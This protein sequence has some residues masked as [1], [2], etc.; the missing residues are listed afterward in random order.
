M[1]FISVDTNEIREFFGDKIPEYAISS[2]TWGAEEVTFQDMVRYHSAERGIIRTR[3][4]SKQG[5]MK[6][7]HTCRDAR[8]D[9][10]GWAWV[11][12]C[13]IDKPSISELSEAI[14]SMFEWYRRSSEC[15]GYLSDVAQPVS[16]LNSHLESL[17][18][19]S[20]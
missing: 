11:D 14:N 8:K 16:K 5:Y 6:I 15:Y 3:I 7:M 10:S 9:N 1:F 19:P 20:R 4:S 12:T 2:H 18:K 17:L 13:C